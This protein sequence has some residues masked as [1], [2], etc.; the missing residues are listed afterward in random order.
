M[1]NSIASCV[2]QIMDACPYMNEVLDD[3][4]ISWANYAE[5]IL[6]RIKKMTGKDCSKAAVVMAV[7]R[8]G[9]ELKRISSDV[10]KQEL[11]YEIVMKT[12][13]IDINLALTNSVLMK[14]GR[15][16]STISVA[17][18]D[19]FNVSL[20]AD[21]IAIAVNEKYRN[22]IEEMIEDE[23]VHAR[24]EDLVALTI[25]FTG[26]FVHTPGTIY[27]V[28]KVLAMN[29]VNVIELSSTLNELI[30]VIK[31]SDST[32]AYDVLREGF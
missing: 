12:N 14:L 18:G 1:T 11:S 30:L 23:H 22:L 19:F 27:K 25:V 20:G 28:L 10:G 13:I 8:Y 6:P 7:R 32:K 29:G 21:E 3:G 5:H 4:I 24:V 26:D 17:K 16:Y 9:E 31:S 15:L 2:K